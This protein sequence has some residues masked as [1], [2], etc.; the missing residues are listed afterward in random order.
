M[1]IGDPRAFKCVCETAW[2]DLTRRSKATKRENIWVDIPT[3][4][5][6]FGAKFDISQATMAPDT[7]DDRKLPPGL[8]SAKIQSDPL[9]S[10]RCS[11]R[12]FLDHV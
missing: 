8:P 9:K 5:G 3:F 12:A 7:A 11:D 1:I 4:D 6:F 10:K 2:L